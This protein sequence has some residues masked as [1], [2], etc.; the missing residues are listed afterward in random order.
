MIKFIGTII[1]LYFTLI[2]Q[3]K[4]EDNFEKECQEVIQFLSNNRNIFID[5]FNKEYEKEG[6]K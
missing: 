1:L 4:V 5:E 3:F 6:K 2:P